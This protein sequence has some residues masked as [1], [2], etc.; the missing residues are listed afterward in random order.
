MKK[1]S[2]IVPIYNTREYLRKCLDSM[3]LQTYP[4]MEF[5][6]INDGS[7]DGSGDILDEYA[8]K[9]KRIVAIHQNNMGE[10]AARNVGLQVMTGDY[11]GF[12][13]CDDWI[14][15]DM[16][17]TLI[18]ALE[19]KDADMAAASWIKETEDGSYVMKNR[20]TPDTEVLNREQLMLCVY[21]RDDFQGFAYMWDK[22]YKRELLYYKSDKM[23]T[24][25]ENIALGGDVIFLGR[26]LLGVKKAVYVD[27]AFY[28]YRQRKSSGC[29]TED[30]SKRMDWLKSYKIL[31]DIFSK[32]QIKENI[33]I[34]VKRFL[35]YHSSNVACLAYEQGLADE[36]HTCQQIMTEYEQEYI[37]TNIN[38]PDRIERYK[39]ILN[40]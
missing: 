36:L 30:V 19:K 16:Y 29:H 28:H 18:E 15:P 9:D 5:V 23:A 14:E 39:K 20:L 7:T 10:S 12:M 24:F 22:L 3:I 27:R 31:L 6:C 11:F 34:W 2:L 21:R 33:T 1:I 4:N 13:D 17:G 35:A 26:M 25:E 37:S 32:E 40:Y 8:K 38:Y